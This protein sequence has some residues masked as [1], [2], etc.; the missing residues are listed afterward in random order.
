MRWAIVGLILA[1]LVAAFFAAIL[2]ASLRTDIWKRDTSPATAMPEVKILVAREDLPAM[3]MVEASAIEEKMVKRDKAPKH[4]LSEPVQ[5]VGK[6]LTVPVVKEQAIT[7]NL[8][9]REGTGMH[10]ASVLPEGKR[11][12]GVSI[13]GYSG[14]VGLLYA[15]SK[16][17]VLASY[18]PT[19]GGESVTKTLL[20]DVPVLSVGG[21]TVVS[22]EDTQAILDLSDPGKRHLVS[23]L[24]DTEEAE[25]L[26]SAMAAG[27]LSLALRNPMDSTKIGPPEKMET[28]GTRPT[29]AAVEMLQES[30]RLRVWEMTILR[31][32]EAER[33]K[34]EIMTVGTEI[35]PE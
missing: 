12:V 21:Q 3:K 2:V 9:A 15:G 5:V 1:G 27:N 17:D 19:V 35:P 8:F 34:F 31:N 13:T 23:L 18:K 20:Q 14:L 7:S 24:V 16:V 28:A 4:Y 25:I 33:K 11:A 29:E 30:P 10:L 22:P 26:Q 32:R 6:V